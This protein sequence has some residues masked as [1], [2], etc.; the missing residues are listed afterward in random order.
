MKQALSKCLAAFAVAAGLGAAV[1]WKSDA[2]QAGDPQAAEVVKQ[3]ADRT[4]QAAVALTAALGSALTA[5]LLK[6]SSADGKPPGANGDG[7]S[8]RWSAPAVVGLACAA[9]LVLP[10]CSSVSTAKDGTVTKTEF[11]PPASV[12]EILGK[13]ADRSTESP[14]PAVPVVKVRAEK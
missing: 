8:G 5:W 3:E 7:G 9:A 14:S 11:N 6:K 2:I 12:W 13:W 1:I 10:A 4:A